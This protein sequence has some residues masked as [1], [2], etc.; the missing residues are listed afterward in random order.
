MGEQGTTLPKCVSAVRF[1]LPEH[2]PGPG[3]G[4]LTAILLATRPA[5]AAGLTHSSV[6]HGSRASLFT[7]LPLANTSTES[8]VVKRFDPKQVVLGQDN[9]SHFSFPTQRC[10]LTVDPM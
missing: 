2:K 5:T 4:W 9:L 6:G 7:W 1:H 3:P 10:F 8:L